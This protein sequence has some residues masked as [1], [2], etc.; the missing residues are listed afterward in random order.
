MRNAKLLKNRSIIDGFMYK[1]VA[2]QKYIATCQY[3]CSM[4]MYKPPWPNYEELYSIKEF[5]ILADLHIA[6]TFWQWLGVDL[7]A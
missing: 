5:A 7:C 1:K 3:S 2:M 4:Y 6:E